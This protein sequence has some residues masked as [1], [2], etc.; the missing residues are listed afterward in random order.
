MDGNSNASFHADLPIG[1]VGLHSGYPQ[2][3]VVANPSKKSGVPGPGSYKLPSFFG[4]SA[5]SK[6]G[7]PVLYKSTRFPNEVPGSGRSPGP[8]YF[9]LKD[10]PMKPSCADNLGFG[11]AER[12]R[13]TFRMIGCGPPPTTY[14]PNFPKKSKTTGTAAFRTTARDPILCDNRTKRYS[15]KGAFLGVRK[16][17]KYGGPLDSTVHCFFGTSHCRPR[18]KTEAE[19]PGPGTYNPMKIETPS[20]VYFNTMSGRKSITSDD[21]MSPFAYYPNVSC[22]AE[23]A[24]CAITYLTEDCR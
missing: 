11:S 10:A 19:T 13:D 22:V 23:R 20:S 3:H 9:A 14:N 15:F 21:R 2:P 12:F 1:R 4:N 5:N 6:K 8:I 7:I 16:K 24:P 17:K 18:S